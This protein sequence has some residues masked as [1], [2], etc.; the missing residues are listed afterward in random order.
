MFPGAPD[1]LSTQNQNPKETI[2]V[3]TEPLQEK[4]A[5]QNLWRRLENDQGTEIYL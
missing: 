2:Q 5:G 3:D 1:V 4:N